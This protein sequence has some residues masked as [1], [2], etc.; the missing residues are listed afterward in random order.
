MPSVAVVG[1]R[2]RARH[3]REPRITSH[4]SRGVQDSESE[5]DG[6]GGATHLKTPGPDEVEENSTYYKVSFSYL[7]VVEYI[8]SIEM[9]LYP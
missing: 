7:H 5:K 2:R 4:N 8:I 9:D 1:G 3:C 6:R